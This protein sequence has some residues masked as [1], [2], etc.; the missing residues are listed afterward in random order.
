MADARRV[1]SIDVAR[2]AGVSR[3]AVSRTF[4]VGASVAAETRAR[5]EAAAAQ[6]GY[7]PNAIARMLITRRSGIVG[8][9]VS[10]LQNPFYARMLDTLGYQLQSAGLMPLLFNCR[11]AHGVDDLLPK[12]LA[13]QV[14]GVIITAATL[15]S[16]MAGEC[17]RAGTPVVLLNRYVRDGAASSVAC[18]NQQ[19]GALVA[20]HLL[21][22]GHRQLGF[23]SGIEDTS[24]SAD[25]EAGFLERAWRAD[26]TVLRRAVG[27]YTY[28]GGMEAARA[29]LSGPTRPQAVFCANDVM[30]IALIDVATEAFGLRV[31]QDLSVAGFDDTA[32]AVWPGYGLTSVDQNIEAMVEQA[33]AILLARIAD[34]GLAPEQRLIM[35]ELRVRGS[36]APTTSG[37]SPTVG[38]SSARPSDRS[39]RPSPRRRATTPEA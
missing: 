10:E 5:V 17:L 24:S 23:I 30:A 27:R 22:L 33:V 8:V 2:L 21:D 16:R 37:V 3:S 1:R 20:E 11:D 13:C 39:A 14:E 6:L 34:P 38:R 9:V 26:G 29:L 31:P 7:R 25:R 28:Q 36:T 15:S 18:A 19:G 4:T 12:L 32:R 35:P